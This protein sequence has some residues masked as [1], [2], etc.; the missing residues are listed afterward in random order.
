M[1]L[2]IDIDDIQK[3]TLGA[4][5]PC[6]PEVLHGLGNFLHMKENL[7]RL[8]CVGI[9]ARGSEFSC[10]TV[11]EREDQQFEQEMR[12]SQSHLPVCAQ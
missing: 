3:V 12:H 9:S 5:A 2:S 7:C 11:Y 6:E 10:L 4:L 8:L 1:I